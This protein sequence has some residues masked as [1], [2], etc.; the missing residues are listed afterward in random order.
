MHRVTLGF[1]NYLKKE[2]KMNGVAISYDNRFG[3]MEFA[4]EAA[5]VL[6]YNGIKSYIFKALRPTHRC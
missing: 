5:K 3:S 2:N 1:A 6:A 4:Y